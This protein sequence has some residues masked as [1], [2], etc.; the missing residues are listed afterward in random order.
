M[1]NLR[2]L[3]AL[4]G[5]LNRDNGCAWPS[6]QRTILKPLNGLGYAVDVYT[7][8]MIGLPITD[9]VPSQPRTIDRNPTFFEEVPADVIDR[10]NAVFCKTTKCKFRPDYD[11]Y[12]GLVNRA[13]RQLWMEHRVSA[14]IQSTNETYQIV[15]AMENSIYLKRAI[16]ESDLITAQK[17]AIMFRSGNND[18]GG[19]T[20]GLY[21]GSPHVISRAM[22]RRISTFFPEPND[23]EA[24]LKRACSHFGI[25]SRVLMGQG[26]NSMA[27]IRHNGH[28]WGARLDWD[29]AACLRN[30]TLLTPLRY[31]LRYFRRRMMSFP[32][33][34]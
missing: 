2:A 24:Q 13:L 23:Y 3:V 28:V 27:K 31:Y 11:N 18:A 1:P 7:L 34:V 29:T 20:N 5:T 16:L 15:V 8:D 22:N 33:L 30:T 25:K 10:E 14:F 9:E 21:V 32:S 12:P 4:Y 19:Y 17:T 6:Q 26:T